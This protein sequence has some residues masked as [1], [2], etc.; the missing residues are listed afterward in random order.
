[1]AHSSSGTEK[2]LSP[3]LSLNYQITLS[4]ASSNQDTDAI[5]CPSTKAMNETDEETTTSGSQES[6]QSQN[7]NSQIHASNKNCLHVVVPALQLEIAFTE[8]GQ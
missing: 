2:L 6:E 1:M 5:F 4:L 7:L 8:K 3:F